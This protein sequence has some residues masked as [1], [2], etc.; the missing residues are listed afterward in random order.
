MRERG[1]ER[2]PRVP[3]LHLSPIASPPF[4]TLSMVRRTPT[5]GLPSRRRVWA[6]ATPQQLVAPSRG[7]RPPS[8]VIDA[9][10]TSPTLPGRGTAVTVS[11]APSTAQPNQSKPGPRLAMVAG[12]KAVAEASVG[13]RGGPACR[14]G[15][16]SSGRGWADGRREARRWL[17]RARCAGAGTRAGVGGRPV[18]TPGRPRRAGARPGAAARVV[19]VECMVWGGGGL[20]CQLR[21]GGPVEWAHRRP[22]GCLDCS[23]TRVR[24][25]SR[26]S[27]RPQR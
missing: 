10:S 21:G 23:L 5:S 8:P 14:I 26:H 2:I 11:P 12:A 24:A 18:R 19:A 17:P 4:H 6:A 16:D 15:V 3:P 7:R 25:A 22:D 9:I 1:R 20:A 13:R 27:S